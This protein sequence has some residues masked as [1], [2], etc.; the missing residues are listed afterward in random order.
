VTARL[1][2]AATWAAVVALAAAVPLS[3]RGRGALAGRAGAVLAMVAVG[4]LTWALATGDFTLA[5]VA[6]TTDRAASWPYR[7]AG[8]W[9]AMAGSLL[10]WAAMVAAWGLRR[11][12]GAVERASLAGL[13]AAVLAVGALLASPWDRLSSP[14]LD[15]AG[16]TPILE[17]PAMLVHPPLLYAGLTGLAVPFAATVGAVALD[18]AWAA[19]VRR[20]LLLCIVALTA[21]MAIGGHWA[22][23]E[24]GWG[25]F[26][27]W[28]PVENTAVMP[29]LA[30]VA[31]VHLLRSGRWRVAGL[32]AS[33]ALVL[34]VL[35]TVLT[36][37]GAT[38]SVHAFAEDAAIGWALL[39]VAAATAVLALR[40]PPSEAA[41]KP[42]PRGTVLA[43]ASAGGA[44]VVVLLGTVRPLVGDA[45][46]AVDGSYYARLVGPVAVGAA[47][48]LVATGAWRRGAVLSHVGFLVLLV[49]V[50]GSTAGASTTAT[51]AVGDV[52]EVGGWQV[53]NDGVRVVD[54]RTVAVD[55]TLL[56]GGDERASLRPSLVAHPDRGG[57]L[58]ETSLRSTP[59]TDVLVA[60]RDAGDDGRALL[61]IHVRP[62]VWW[63]WWG[64]ALLAAGALRMR[65][66]TA[67]SAAAQSS[68]SSVRSS[69]ESVA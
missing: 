9:G 51:V 59:L 25:G 22:Y 26:W 54:D 36:R 42:V 67:P 19:R 64:A 6:E 45:A 53:R 14:A 10:L 69:S 68:T 48:V 11:R 50:L 30:A 60:L 17:H 46:V 57:L 20:Q 29:W 66:V 39:A 58:A 41:A 38:P 63:V 49:G 18:A 28:D 37:S 65:Y 35:G 21:G 44:L 55:V 27:A 40:A 1:G 62:L 32:A 43:A 8:L 24:V 34:A 52:V 3:L 16:L 61:E 47:V 56:R 7:I 31:A 2:E 4:C 23:A 33:G 15:G 13:A 12:L 5:Y